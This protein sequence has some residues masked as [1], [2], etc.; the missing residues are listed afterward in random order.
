MCKYIIGGL[1]LII[2]SA[3]VATEAVE[4]PNDVI[5]KPAEVNAATNGSLSNIV[6]PSK[7]ST[8]YWVIRSQAV[9]E[10]I[11]FLTKKRAEL[12]SKLEYFK[13][14]IEEIGK[15]QDMLASNIQG[16]DDPNLRAQALGIFDE[17]QSRGIAVPKKPL[18][19]EELVEVG[20]RF[21]ISEGYLPVDINEQELVGFKNTLKKNEQLCIKVRKETLEVADKAVKAW[22]YLGTIGKQK[23]FRFYVIDQKQKQEQA[24]EERHLARQ[25]QNRAARNQQRLDEQ[26]NIW[27]E[28]QQ[29]RTERINDARERQSRREDVYSQNGYSSYNQY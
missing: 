21:E 8:E 12:R 2:S 5:A 27:Q 1:V 11:S 29:G 9:N 26:Q 23:E 25:E 3:C 13:S 14:Y 17:M 18:S 19:W 15:T 7:D 4:S 24:R 10:L 16:S 28:K 6:L 22:L 20:M